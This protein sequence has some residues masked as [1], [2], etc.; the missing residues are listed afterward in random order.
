MP[1]AHICP[2]CGENLA[3]LPAAREPHYGW[4]LLKCP[5]CAT[6]SVRSEPALLRGWRK[7]RKAQAALR[8][9]AGRV[10]WFGAVGGLII[11]MSDELARS[12]LVYVHTRGSGGSVGSGLG[13]L[14]RDMWAGGERAAT[15]ME[16]VRS[17]DT[18]VTLFSWSVGAIMAT[19]GLR[20]LLRHRRW[21]MAAACWTGL[22]AGAVVLARVVVPFV[23][24]RL[25]G[26]NGSEAAE[27]LAGLTISTNEHLA[28]VTLN[29]AFTAALTPIG[30]IGQRTMSSLIRKQRWATR[31]RIRRSRQSL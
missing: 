26:A 16:W 18:P 9:F 24:A 7:F 1:H 31:R 19:I 11:G 23:G 29:G 13:A 2:S 22:L 5:S 30:N 10:L 28:W 20:A 12:A 14:L 27:V 17:P 15:A 21:W 6:P 4:N 3:L 25:L 8:G